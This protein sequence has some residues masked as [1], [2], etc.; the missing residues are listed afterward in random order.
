MQNITCTK[1]RLRMQLEL[2]KWLDRRV[3]GYTH[4]ITLS[5]ND[6]MRNADHARK[7]LRHWDA[8]LNNDFLGPRWQKKPDERTVWFACMEGKNSAVHWHIL[9]RLSWDMSPSQK[10]CAESANIANTID[11]C[12]R[13][14]TPLGSTKTLKVE[15]GGA[16]DYVTKRLSSLDYLAEFEDSM[17]LKRS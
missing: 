1:D 6:P 12:W 17:F 3:Q 7:M 5:T 9:W 4:F 13:K 8:L 14:T 10:A 11:R 15:D 16:Q 2:R